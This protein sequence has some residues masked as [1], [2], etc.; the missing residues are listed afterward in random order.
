MVDIDNTLWDFAPVLYERI[1]EIN[2]Y[3]TEPYLWHDIYFWKDY[4]TPGE[5]YRIILSIHEDQEIFT[6]YPDAQLFLS[7]LKDMGFHITIASHRE[8]TTIQPTVN[9]LKKY[10]LIFDDIHLS[11]DKTVLFDGCQYIIDDSPIIMDK[12]ARKGIPCYGL[13]MP[14]NERG[15][16]RIFDTLTDILHYISG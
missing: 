4:V 16:Y 9:W 12:A 13:K 5:F 3:I 10:D 1:K 2:P 15:N 11:Y 7:S 8:R 6:P 14:W